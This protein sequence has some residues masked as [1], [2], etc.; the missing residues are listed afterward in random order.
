MTKFS[1]VNQHWLPLFSGPRLLTWQPIRRLPVSVYW[2]IRPLFWHHFHYCC[3]YVRHCVRSPVCPSR[4]LTLDK[5]PRDEKKFRDENLIFPSCFVT[6]SHQAY[7]WIGMPLLIFEQWLC[8]DLLSLI[9]Y[10]LS[11]RVG[12]MF[13]LCLS[14][15]FWSARASQSSPLIGWKLDGNV[16]LWPRSRSP[17]LPPHCQLCP[18]QWEPSFQVTWPI[19]TNERPG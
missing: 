14:P 12:S 9:T 7:D 3:R 18:S 8:G 13:W 11:P 2:P 1:F 15:R 10:F 4:M 6:A 5:C 19:L 17:L 16:W